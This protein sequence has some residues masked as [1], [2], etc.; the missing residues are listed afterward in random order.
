MRSLLFVALTI[1]LASCAYLGLSTVGGPYSAQAN[2]RADIQAALLAAQADH[3]FVLLDFGANWCAPCHELLSYFHTQRADSFLQANFHLV[4][5]DIGQFD[6]NT[7]VVRKYGFATSLGI[8]ALAVLT[9]SGEVIAVARGK[10]LSPVSSGDD[11]VRFLSAWI[12]RTSGGGSTRRPLPV[13]FDPGQVRSAAET[14]AMRTPKASGG[15]FVLQLD[16]NRDSVTSAIVNTWQDTL[17]Q[18]VRTVHD[19]LSLGPKE[20]WDSTRGEQVHIIYVAGRVRGTRVTP[21][22]PGPPDTIHF[23]LLTDP[24]TVDRR[25]L[26]LIVS[27]LALAP[28]TNAVIPV[29]DS[30]TLRTYSVRLVIGDRIRVT[31]PSGTVDG[32][33][34]DLSG[35]MWNLPQTWYVSADLP[36]RILRVEWPQDAVLE[37]V[38]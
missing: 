8:P 3:K 38:R 10:S 11:V 15:T 33:R 16:V 5:I 31:R 34:I 2:P 21:N 29:F 17:V 36:R 22:P 14:L 4:Y 30:W 9:S 25:N 19:A 37:A 6:R 35:E 27:L 23:D 12:N 7:D 26:P 1:G 20:V 32:Y 24:N 28:S 18:H 13:Q